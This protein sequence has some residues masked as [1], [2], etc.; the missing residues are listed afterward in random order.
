VTQ[1][2]PA[3]NGYLPLI[4]FVGVLFAERAFPI[5]VHLHPFWALRQ[6]AQLFARRVHPS[7]KRPRSQQRIS[8]LMAM[9]FMLLFWVALPALLYS[10]AELKV[11]FAAVILWL[12]LSSQPWL[13]EAQLIQ[14]SLQR[15]QKQLARVRLQRWLNRDCESLSALGIEKAASEQCVKRQL[16]GWFGVLFWFAVAGPIAALCYRVCFELNRAWPV[17]LTYW[18]DFG[19]VNNALFRLLNWPPYFITLAVLT[20]AESFA[21]YRRSMGHKARFNFSHFGD[22][23][24][25]IFSS[26][27][28]LFRL[29]LGGPVKYQGTKIKRLR[30]MHSQPLP[31]NRIRHTILCLT[32]IQFPLFIIAL[33][34]TYLRVM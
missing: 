34:I 5:P 25:Q 22:H 11:W 24:Q 15:G 14:K 28:R 9:L 21:S 23:E 20:V 16:Q 27:T 8:G 7:N 26:L 18:R 19:A 3:I 2:W 12:C 32:C 13:R 31:H 29:E 30:F 4:L 33:G 6:M 10:L 17:Q 1:Y